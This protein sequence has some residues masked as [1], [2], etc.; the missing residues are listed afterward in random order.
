M[1]DLIA[2]PRGQDPWGSG[3]FGAPRGSRTHTGVDI[4]A[5]PGSVVKVF[6]AGR[7]TGFG[8]AYASGVGGANGDCPFRIIDVHCID[9]FDM[10]YFYVKPLMGVQVGDKVSM[11]E[12]IGVAQDLWRRYPPELDE[13]GKPKIMT[14]HIHFEIIGPNGDHVDPVTYSCA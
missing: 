1:I 8:Y 9:G 13:E 6:Q 5:W 14:P 10:R 2:P 4:A 11:G 3:H 12:P 7:I